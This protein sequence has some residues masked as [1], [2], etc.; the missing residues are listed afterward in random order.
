MK[1]HEYQ[2]KGLFREYGIPVLTGAVAGSP[3]QAREISS[4]I[5]KS[6]VIKAQIHA[7]GRG[8][9]GGIKTADTPEE[10][11][12]QS[13]SILSRR[14]VTPQTGPKGAKVGKVLVEEAAEIKEEL[15]LGVTFDSSARLPVI[16]A[17]SRGGVDIEEV[18]RTG[19]QEI[20][21]AFPEP[22]FP[23]PAFL[24]RK[25]AF[26]VKLDSNL[27][28]QAQDIISRL[29]RLFL[30]K[31]C[32]LAEINP[33]AVLRDGKLIALDAKL[34][35]DD[36]ALFRHP[37]IASLYDPEQETDLEE[38]ANTLQIKN[39]VR[40]NGNIG[41][42][43]NGAGLAMSVL[44][45]VSLVGGKAANFLDIGTLNSSER[46]VNAFKIFHSD[47]RVKAILVNIFGGMARTD[48]IATGI[49]EASKAG[50][51]RKPVVIRLAGTNVEEGNK[52]LRE[53]GLPLIYAVDMKEAAIKAVEE[54]KKSK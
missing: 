50:L 25:L 36:N 30:E 12:I 31:D 34:E 40:L 10:A 24:L 13:S 14:L 6:V 15:Y 22:Y 23:A 21:K 52:I 37:D 7:G 5:K 42:L 20:I 11:E 41:C 49:V 3:A 4:D 39:Y 28:A 32:S 35:F 9:G 27:H 29:F 26:G 1:I 54:V 53:S 44:D 45:I 8:K 43:V 18:S 47:N 33:L 51:V 17:S 19:P 16:I 48:I 38:L 46:V 2:A